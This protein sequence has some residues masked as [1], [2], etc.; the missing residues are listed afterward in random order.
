MKNFGAAYSVLLD[1]IKILFQLRVIHS[2]T[3]KQFSGE[4]LRTIS[5]NR[6]RIIRNAHATFTDLARRGQRTATMSRSFWHKEIA[7][8]KKENC[9]RGYKHDFCCFTHN[10]L[11][12]SNNFNL[13]QSH[14]KRHFRRFFYFL[15]TFVVALR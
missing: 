10:I 3:F 7:G 13:S 4:T 8:Q 14:K 5:S 9:G 6:T 12:I 11:I 2:L 1:V 15:Q